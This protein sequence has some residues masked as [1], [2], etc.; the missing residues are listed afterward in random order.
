MPA[1]ASAEGV[2]IWQADKRVDSAEN[3][4]QAAK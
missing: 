4:W 3:I 2:T 1:P